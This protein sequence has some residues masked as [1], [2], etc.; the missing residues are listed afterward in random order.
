M[1]IPIFQNNSIEPHNFV[2]SNLIGNGSYKLVSSNNT[3][4]A[5]FI[6]NEHYFL[7]N[8]KIDKVHLLGCDTYQLI[9]LISNIL[10]DLTI[11]DAAQIKR[12]PK[13]ILEKY[14]IFSLPQL[15]STVL[16]INPNSTLFYSLNARKMISHSIN[17]NLLVH[18]LFSDYAYPQD[19]F[20]PRIIADHFDTDII[21][22][23]KS[24]LSSSIDQLTIGYSRGNNEHR[25]VAEFLKNNLKDKAN[26]HIY[27][28]ESK[29]EAFNNK[30]DLYISQMFHTMTPV[31]NQFIYNNANI[32]KQCSD[33]LKLIDLDT[34]LF[35]QNWSLYY[36]E[37][38]TE[39]ANV[40]PVIP[41]YSKHEIQLVSKNIKNI[42]P[43]SRG[44]FWNIHEIDK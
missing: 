40:L 41:L 6:K 30:A 1:T 21:Y 38:M 34:L 42:K 28:F 3:D 16:H 17:R 9:D 43:D 19:Q 35:G 31:S 44:A 24:H 14:R 36:R 11:V 7:G 39:T 37:Y 22:Y 32:F 8:P 23:D 15:V 20:I 4:E 5:H 26:I 18:A 25:M 13:S 33:Y 12:I 29:T 10:P 2:C 27:P